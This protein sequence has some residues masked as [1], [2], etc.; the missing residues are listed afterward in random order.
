MRLYSE[1]S[2]EHLRGDETLEFLLGGVEAEFNVLV[3]KVGAHAVA[4]LQSLHAMADILSHAIY[5]SLGMNIGTGAL[6]ETKISFWAV[7]ERLKIKGGFEST[8]AAIETLIQSDDYQYLNA[9]VNLS[10]H[11]RVV[12]PYLPPVWDDSEREAPEFSFKQFTYVEKEYEPR[13]IRNAVVPIYEG[14]TKLVIEVG[15]EINAHLTRVV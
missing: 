5:F 14:L 10:K 3:V 7:K 4:C 12:V 9:A 15:N 11:R 6:S 13:T 1:F 8:V 2:S